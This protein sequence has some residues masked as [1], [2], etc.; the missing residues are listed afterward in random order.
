[1]SYEMTDPRA[2]PLTIGMTY[3]PEARRVAVAVDGNEVLAHPI[4]M[5]ITAPV[6]VAVGENFSDPGLTSRRF[7]GSLEVLKRTISERTT[8]AESRSPNF[9]DSGRCAAE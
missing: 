1:M 8:P 5:L 2:R 6:Q 9:A 4:E 3:C 7:P